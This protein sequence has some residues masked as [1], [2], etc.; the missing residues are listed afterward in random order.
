MP[1]TIDT[2]IEIAA[3]DEQPYRELEDGSKFTKADVVL[4]GGADIITDATF[5]A[6]M[7]YRPDGTSSYVTLMRAT[8]TFDGKSGSFALRGDGSY[9]GTTARMQSTLIEGSATGEL[10]GL[11][12]TIDSTSTHADY[13]FMPLTVNYSFA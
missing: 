7:Y 2:R 1:N 13:P 6:L 11:T 5:E 8:G 9:D 4:S 12:A 10:A 3:W